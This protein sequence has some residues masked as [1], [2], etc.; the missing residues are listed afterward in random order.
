MLGVPAFTNQ[1]GDHVRVEPRISRQYGTYY[2]NPVDEIVAVDNVVTAF[3]SKPEAYHGNYHMAYDYHRTAQTLAIDEP[4]VTRRHAVQSSTDPEKFTIDLRTNHFISTYRTLGSYYVPDSGADNAYDQ[5][6]TTA[7]DSL[8]SGYAGLGEDLG[9]ARQTC[10]EFAGVALKMG[11]FLKN[12]RDANFADA[13]RYLFGS[14]G[15]RPKSAVRNIADWWLTYSY[16]FKP[17]AQDLYEAQMVVH[18]VLE[19]PVFVN[20]N[21]KGKSERTFQDVFSG[22]FEFIN[23]VQTNSSHQT[24]LI[25]QMENPYLHGLASAGLINPLSIAWELVPFSFVIDW[26]IPI[27]NTLQAITAGVGLTF[28]GGYT[29]SHYGYQ[30]RINVRE[31]VDSDG[32]G[33]VDGGDYLDLGHTFKRTA[34]TQLPGPRIYANVRPYSTTRALNA[35]AVLAG[36]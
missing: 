20:G 30:T 27:G 14:K 2:Q 7:L 3:S 18:R 12:V 10:N 8:N 22:D 34:H 36:L 29:S 13:F 11:L 25:S 19:A 9:Q 15:A 21:G 1:T 24:S 16:G 33:V 26:F 28:I 23:S 5:S 4:F 35:L 32:S 31:K 6:I 17:L